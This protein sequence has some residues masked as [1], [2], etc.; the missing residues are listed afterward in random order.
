MGVNDPQVTRELVHEVVDV[1]GEKGVAGV[2]ARAD[3][4]GVDPV[5]VPSRIH[6]MSL[7]FPKSKCGSLFS[8]NA[9]DTQ[10]F[11]TSGD[12]IQ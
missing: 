1:A 11:A 6:R 12:M 5:Q 3:F 10:L 2:E 7:V 8:S 9:N 4:G